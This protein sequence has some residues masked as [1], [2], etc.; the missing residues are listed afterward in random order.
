MFLD[1][2]GKKRLKAG[3]HTH[4]TNSDGRLSPDE[5]IALYGANGYDIL[6]LTDHWKYAPTRKVGDITVL[7]GCEYDV[8]GAEK[9]GG[10]IEIVFI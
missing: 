2:T 7:S 10:I 6:A 4:T 8:S 3:F 5:A 9:E 1:M